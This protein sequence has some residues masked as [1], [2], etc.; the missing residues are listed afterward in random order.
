MNPTF[1]SYKLHRVLGAAALVMVIV[2]LATYAVL[3]TRTAKITKD[4][5][6]SI[7]VTGRGET[8]VTPNV[9]EFTFSVI[10]KEDAADKAQASTSARA[11]D[12]IATVKAAGIED[13]DIKTTDF[14]VYPHYSYAPQTECS[15]EQA[16]N[17]GCEFAIEKPDGFEAVQT[18]S[19]K[20]RDITKAGGILASITKKGA[21]NISGLSFTVDDK[22][23]V[24][25]GAREKAIE[26]AQ[27][28][29]EKIAGQ[30]GMHVKRMTSYYDN[31]TSDDPFA[32]DSSAYGAESAKSLSG[33]PMLPAGEQTVKSSVSISFELE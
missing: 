16:M 19:V 26:D 7:S 4:S 33:E 24:K 28:Q 13:K 22:R 15:E 32:A 11:A 20:V 12:V 23:A 21:T 25:A 5:T 6:T 30:F 2:A 27:M 10:T 9:A 29:A 8:K 14:N 31:D 3:N 1:F 17:G 18:V